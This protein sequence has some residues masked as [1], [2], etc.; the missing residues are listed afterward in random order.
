MKKLAT[1]GY[2]GADFA[3]FVATLHIAGVR[4]VIDVR[5]L[6]LSRRK[7]FSK[8]ALSNALSVAGI[9]Y[10]HLRALG[11]PK[12]GRIAARAGKF[13]AFLTI[14]SAHMRSPS[15]KAALK[16]AIDIACKSYSCLLCFERDPN[17]CHRTLIADKVKETGLFQIVNLGV[18]A[19]IAHESS[20]QK[21]RA[22]SDASEGIAAA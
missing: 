7:G 1:I 18:R 10:F 11:D 19:G 6:P 2:E 13:D 16:E 12:T 8:N 9:E 5:E 22:R 21:A 14:Y 20:A 15:A 17:H 3:D 4:T